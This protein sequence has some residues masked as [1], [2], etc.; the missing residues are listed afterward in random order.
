MNCVFKSGWLFGFSLKYFGLRKRSPTGGQLAKSPYQPGV[1]SLGEADDKYITS[2]WKACTS[3][4]LALRKTKHGC[5]HIARVLR[6]I[7][8]NLSSIV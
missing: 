2:V 7:L 6:A 5:T 8:A 4:G 3:A 1:S